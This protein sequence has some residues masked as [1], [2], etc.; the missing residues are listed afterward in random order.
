MGRAEIILILS[1]ILAGFSVFLFLYTLLNTKNDK[2][3]LAWSE[4][5]KKAEP[6]NRFL[7]RIN[8]LVHQ[9]TLK[10]ALKIKNKKYRE[11]LQKTLELS[12]Y[13]EQTT[14]DEFIGSQLL[15]GVAFPLMLLLINFALE[16][17]IDLIIFP[18]LMP[19]GFMLPIIDANAAIT[20]RRHS[21]RSDLPFFVDLLALSTEAGMEFFRAIQRIIDKTPNSPLSEELKK[22]IKDINLG[23]NRVDALKGMANRLDMPEITSFVAVFADATET[24]ASINNVLKDQSS[25][26]RS[27]RFARA[28]KAGAK[29]SQSILLPVI[30]FILPA[31]MIV[32]LGP[33]I[34]QFQGGGTP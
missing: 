23:S 11:K 19:L 25:Q 24:G 29:A 13:D 22:V 28:E 12:A 9:F 15:I 27:D 21:I 6:K 8:P 20:N 17:G 16:M 33:V 3:F 18:I 4:Q 7:A 34:L 14:V 32:V 5:N 2:D 31:L 30:L 26:M 1:L 10:Y